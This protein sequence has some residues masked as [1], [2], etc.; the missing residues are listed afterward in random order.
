MKITINDEDYEILC[1]LLEVKP[2]KKTEKQTY[3][4][5]F[6]TKGHMTVFKRLE[7]AETPANKLSEAISAV[8]DEVTGELSRPIAL[9]DKVNQ[10]GKSYQ[11]GQ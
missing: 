9:L 10:A 4:L 7:L 1:K 8:V 3:D 2:V 5:T 6:G 11:E